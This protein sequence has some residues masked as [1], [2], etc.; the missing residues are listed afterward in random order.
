MGIDKRKKAG[1]STQ[2]MGGMLAFH[3]AELLFS[4]LH[5]KIKSVGPGSPAQTACLNLLLP[6]HITDTKHLDS[7]IWHYP[8]QVD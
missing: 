4:V 3:S 7:G 1:P 6:V 2:Q 5:L 8:G